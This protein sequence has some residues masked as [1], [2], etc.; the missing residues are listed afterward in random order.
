MFHEQACEVLIVVS[1]VPVIGLC[2][3]ALGETRGFKDRP[4]T[5]PSGL[6]A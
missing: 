2:Y 5:R 4:R 3:S 6:R 1:S